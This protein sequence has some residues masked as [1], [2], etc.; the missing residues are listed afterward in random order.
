MTTILFYRNP[1][2]FRLV[3]KILR[4]EGFDSIEL[5]DGSEVFKRYQEAG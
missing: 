1:E 5:E 2:L 3:K 4:K